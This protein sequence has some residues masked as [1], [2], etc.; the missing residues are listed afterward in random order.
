MNLVCLDLIYK[1][2][3]FIEFITTAENVMNSINATRLYIKSRQ[4]KF[5]YIEVF[6]IVLNIFSVYSWFP[7]VLLLIIP[8]S[9]QGWMLYFESNRFSVRCL[10]IITFTLSWF[11]SI[12]SLRLSYK[13]RSFQE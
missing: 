12:V 13:N 6:K 11:I 7:K 1:R 10:I 9:I 3:A 2:V 4:T 5:I 8:L